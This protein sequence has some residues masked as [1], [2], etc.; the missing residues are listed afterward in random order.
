MHGDGS[1]RAAMYFLL[2]LELLMNRFVVL[3]T[4]LPLPRRLILDVEEQIS[5]SHAS[6]DNWQHQQQRASQLR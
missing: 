6:D 5:P 1:G 4:L 3:C 2:L